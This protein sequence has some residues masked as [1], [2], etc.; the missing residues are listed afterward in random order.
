MQLAIVSYLYHN[1][2]EAL[3]HSCCINKNTNK[4]C[5]AKCIVTKTEK[6]Q[7]ESNQ[8]L[9]KKIELI[10]DCYLPLSIDFPTF[11]T[12]LEEKTKDAYQNFYHQSNFLDI[13]TPPRV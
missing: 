4:N 9:S 5:K 3:T 11:A 13:E 8:E 2:N 6:Q 10:P 1:H 12:C 7:K